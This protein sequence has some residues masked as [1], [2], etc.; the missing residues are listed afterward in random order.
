MYVCIPML[1][2]PDLL[3]VRAYYAV[4]TNGRSCAAA[5]NIS[6]TFLPALKQLD[7]RRPRD[8]VSSVLTH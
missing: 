8:A 5:T 6:E 4:E 3:E 7:C 1:Y 2:L